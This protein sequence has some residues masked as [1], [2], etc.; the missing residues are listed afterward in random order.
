MKSSLTR[1][2]QYH[3]LREHGQTSKMYIL[4]MGIMDLFLSVIYYYSAMVCV[5][6]KRMSG[7]ITCMSLF[8]VLIGLI[9]PARQAQAYTLAL[10][11]KDLQTMTEIWFPYRQGTAV[12]DVELSS[13][14]VILRRDSGRMGFA[15]A[16]RLEMPGQYHATGNGLIDGE[17]DYNAERGEF[18]LR[19]PR[20]IQ[21]AV[22][23][24]PPSYDALVKTV[25]NDLTQQHFPLIVVY[26]L[27]KQALGHASV[28]RTLKSVRVHDG[29]LLVELG[30]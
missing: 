11:Q 23:G 22:D 12:G 2:T 15:V 28:L 3:S 8:I 25:I 4:N 10:S 5:P 9:I 19:E 30:L 1:N 16:I 26:R 13:P 29:K 7:R 21:L 27:E 17:L 6:V 20:L 14:R 18:Y 24:L